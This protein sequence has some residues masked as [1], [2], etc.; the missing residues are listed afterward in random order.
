MTCMVWLF[1]VW[2]CNPC[3]QSNIRPDLPHHIADK[4]LSAMCVRAPAPVV[5]FWPYCWLWFNEISRHA[6]ILN[7]R[8]ITKTFVYRTSSKVSCC[9]VQVDDQLGLQKWKGSLSCELELWGQLGCVG[10]AVCF[11]PWISISLNRRLKESARMLYRDRH[12]PDRSVRKTQE[13]RVP[14]LKRGVW[15]HPPRVWLSLGQIAQK[16]DM[17][18][19][20]QTNIVS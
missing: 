3:C 17:R 1:G 15:V 16:L 10:V 20:V 11:D 9:V 7:P 4:I 18:L 14:L 5:Q 8:F 19:D 6:Q 13:N 2:W 12:P